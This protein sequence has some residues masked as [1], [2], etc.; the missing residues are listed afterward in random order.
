MCHSCWN[1]LQRALN[2][3][4][5]VLSIRMKCEPNTPNVDNSTSMLKK[6]V[7]KSRCL[8]RTSDNSKYFLWSHRLRVN[9]FQ[10]YIQMH[11]INTI[12]ESL[13]H[14]KNVVINDSVNKVINKSCFEM[15][16]NLYN[17][18]L[19]NKSMTSKPVSEPYEYQI[20]HVKVMN[21][22]WNVPNTWTW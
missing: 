2:R 13:Q 15:C 18:I 8:T 7:I 5:I 16:Y 21:L 1:L 17:G 19:Y 12:W 4:Y 22:N 11:K 20:L 9:E 6:T 14:T 10:L 3:L